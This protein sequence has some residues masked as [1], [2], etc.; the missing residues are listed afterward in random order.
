MQTI[1][2][3]RVLSWDDIK[4]T[5]GSP[6]DLHADFVEDLVYNVSAY[7]RA[8]QSGDADRLAVAA[9]MLRREEAGYWATFETSPRDIIDPQEPAVIAAHAHLIANTVFNREADAAADAFER[10]T[11]LDN[12]TKH[13]RSARDPEGRK[14]YEDAEARMIE[15]RRVYPSGPTT[16]AELVQIRRALSVRVTTG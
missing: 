16:S 5:A 7:Y 11:D 13:Y 2:R 14:R 8:M 6:S 4:D 3:T 1:T 10:I 15:Y 12:D 9:E